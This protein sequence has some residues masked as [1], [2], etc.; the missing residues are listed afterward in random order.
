MKDAMSSEHNA[1]QRDCG[2]AIN[3]ESQT[4]RE[5]VEAKVEARD[6]MPEMAPSPN[7]TLQD[8]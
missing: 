7:S 5:K 4:E 8:G 3:V 2:W 1:R 6:E